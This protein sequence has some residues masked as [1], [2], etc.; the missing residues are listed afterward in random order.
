MCLVKT[1]QSSDLYTNLDSIL[2]TVKE[3][4]YVIAQPFNDNEAST[5]VRNLIDQ[6]WKVIETVDSMVL[7]QKSN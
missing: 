6:G 4:G 5:K 1:D 7:I 3:N 2:S